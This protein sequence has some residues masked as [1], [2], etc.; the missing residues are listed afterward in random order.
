M[1]EIGN[2]NVNIVRLCSNL[3]KETRDQVWDQIDIPISNQV[4]D[5][6]CYVIYDLVCLQV[7]RHTSD[8]LTESNE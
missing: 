4:N 7:R 1:N 8:Q 5:Q 3:F 6:L 2:V